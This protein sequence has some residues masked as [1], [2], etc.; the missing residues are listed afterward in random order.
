MTFSFPNQSL[1][2]TPNSWG[3]WD[4]W[5]LPYAPFATLANAVFLFHALPSGI[6]RPGAVRSSSLYWKCFDGDLILL[7]ATLYRPSHVQISCVTLQQ[8]FQGFCE[9]GWGRSESWKQFVKSYP[10]RNGFHR[11]PKQS[12]LVREKYQTIYVCRKSPELV[13]MGP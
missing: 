10:S 6:S 8:Y 11:P 9:E 3:R 5:Y 12:N 1:V 4:S 7:R 13:V 2:Q